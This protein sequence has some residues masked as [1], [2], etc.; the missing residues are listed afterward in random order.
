MA[1][2]FMSHLLQTLSQEFAACPADSVMDSIARKHNVKA[3]WSNQRKT[4][5]DKRENND[6]RVSVRKCNKKT[7]DQMVEHNGLA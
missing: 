5:D 1:D 4:A 2:D 3:D 6:C 7:T